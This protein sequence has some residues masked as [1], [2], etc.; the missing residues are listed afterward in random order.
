MLLISQNVLAE[1]KKS[2][3]EELETIASELLP[4]SSEHHDTRMQEFMEAVEDDDYKRVN[5]MLSEALE[6]YLGTNNLM[7]GLG[8]FCQ[9]LDLPSDILSQ[10]EFGVIEWI[11]GH[12]DEIA[13]KLEEE[14]QNAAN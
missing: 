5:T 4:A 9:R 12:Y 3:K 2:G 10:G 7:A 14:M 13:K 1:A 11:S 6:R 8:D